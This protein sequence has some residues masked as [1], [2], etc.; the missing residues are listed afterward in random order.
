MHN[1]IL[2]ALCHKYK[3]Q[4]RDAEQLFD[5]FMDGVAADENVEQIYNKVNA[6][7]DNWVE[8]DLKLGALAVLSGGAPEPFERVSINDYTEIFKN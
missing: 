1:L 8:A 5:F 2:E 6:A 3:S 4:K 7:V